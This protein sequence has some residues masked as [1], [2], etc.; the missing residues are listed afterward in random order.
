MRISTMAFLAAAFLASLLALKSIPASAIET[1]PAGAAFQSG[2][3]TLAQLSRRCRGWRFYCE[4]R[5][6]AKGGRYRGCMAIHG[7]AGGA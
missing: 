6:P 1:A 3:A 2:A 7:C 5:H 4:A